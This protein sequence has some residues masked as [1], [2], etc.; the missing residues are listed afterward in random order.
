MNEL[1]AKYSVVLRSDL[2]PREKE[3]LN[4]FCGKIGSSDGDMLLHFR[5][6]KIDLS[7]NF[8]IEME[9]FKPGDEFTHPVRVPHHYVFL[10]SGDDSRQPIGFLATHP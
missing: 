10:I 7:R 3:L 1:V 2:P 6:T 8:Y 4:E 9:S 5:C